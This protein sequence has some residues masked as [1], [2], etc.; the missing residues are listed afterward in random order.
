MSKK[1]VDLTGMSIASKERTLSNNEDSDYISARV[2]EYVAE[3]GQAKVDDVFKEMKE[4]LSVSALDVASA[5]YQLSEFNYIL[6]SYGDDSVSLG[7]SSLGY[8]EIKFK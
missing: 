1:K 5:L 7:S 8:S 3:K 4:R 6:Y 2:L